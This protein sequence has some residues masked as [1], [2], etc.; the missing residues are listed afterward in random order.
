MPMFLAEACRLG[1]VAA[2]WPNPARDDPG[3]N[4]KSKVPQVSTHTSLPPYTLRLAHGKS[5]AFSEPVFRRVRA[6]R[7]LFYEIPV[8]AGPP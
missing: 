8:N 1:I 3:H 7:L 6:F 4:P 5:L 2:L